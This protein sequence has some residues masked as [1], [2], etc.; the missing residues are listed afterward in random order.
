MRPPVPPRG[1]VPRRK[2]QILA[3]SDFIVFIERQRHEVGETVAALTEESDCF[4]IAWPGGFREPVIDLHEGVGHLRGRHITP[5]SRKTGFRIA[6]IRLAAY[7]ATRRNAG[8][9]QRLLGSPARPAAR[10]GN[11]EGERLAA[12]LIPFFVALGV[13]LVALTLVLGLWARFPR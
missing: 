7:R 6:S 12:A 11:R 13:Y 2:D 4:A 5:N 10:N 3:S 8:G 1:V 9:S